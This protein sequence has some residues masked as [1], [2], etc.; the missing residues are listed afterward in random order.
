MAFNFTKIVGDGTSQTVNTNDVNTEGV[1]NAISA[2]NST[3]GDL[4]FNVI[5]DGVV[6]SQITV[7][8]NDTVEFQNKINLPQSS[9][10]AVSAP[11]GVSV[12]VNYVLQAVDVS[13]GI[14][15][16]QGLIATATS[17][18]ETASTSVGN[19]SSYKGAY[20]AGTTYS[21]GESVLSGGKFW[22]SDVDANLGNTPAEDAF[23]SEVP[24][25]RNDLQEG[26]S[27]KSV[28][29]FSSSGALVIDCS[30]GNG[31]KHVKTENT[32]VSF[33]NVPN[34]EQFFCFTLELVNDAADSGFV[35]TWPSSVRVVKGVAPVPSVGANAVDVYTLFTMDAGATMKLVVSGQEFTNIV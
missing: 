35:I 3:G 21:T 10:L 29:V 1:V 2:I 19:L 34:T 33:I 15:V 18:I 8:A 30:L 4:T 11:S 9:T 31:F 22:I 24:V 16:V 14:S 12:S 20:A 17:T 6:A 25:F 23:W 27:E 26:L 28:E 13:A 32:T 5:L 7:P